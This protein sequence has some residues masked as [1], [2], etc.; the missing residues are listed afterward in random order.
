MVTYFDHENLAFT[1]DTAKGQLAPVVKDAGSLTVEAL[2]TKVAEVSERASTGRI[3]PDDLAGG[4]FTV[5]D[6]GSNGA[7]LDT[8]VVHLPQVAVL[9]TGAV[10]KRAVVID[11]ADAGESIAVRQ[12][13][14]VTLSY[15]QRLIDGGDAYRF[16]GDLKSR[17]EAAQFQL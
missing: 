16:L 4:T 9:G 12:M 2:A 11:D 17:I 13:A 5:A 8:P 10:V 15:D 6:F 14:Y 7:L 1:V 3:T